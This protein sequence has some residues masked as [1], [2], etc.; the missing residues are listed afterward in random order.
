MKGAMT[1]AHMITV[2][3]DDLV[4]DQRREFYGLVYTLTVNGK[5]Y[6]ATPDYAVLRQ[7]VRN[8]TAEIVASAVDC[9]RLNGG[10]LT[11]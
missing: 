10:F 4:I 1:M 2:L 11:E 8:L 7:R 6:T 3:E 9:I 5:E